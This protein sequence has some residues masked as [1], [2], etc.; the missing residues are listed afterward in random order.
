LLRQFSTDN[1]ERNVRVFLQ[2]FTQRADEG[3]AAL[4]QEMRGLAREARHR[5]ELASRELS[6]YSPFS[7]L[8]RGYAVV[9]HRRTRRVLVSAERVREGDGVD[10]RLA[11]GAL[12][13]TVEGI[14]AGEE[15]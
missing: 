11:K 9:T 6:S 8:E 4:V 1:L 15:Q 14:D 3:H 10:I 13:A 7:I 12:Q 2:P 5:L